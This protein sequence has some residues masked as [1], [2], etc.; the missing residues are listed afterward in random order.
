MHFLLDIAV[1]LHH[2]LVQVDLVIDEV[3][4]HVV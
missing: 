1:L 3:S 4:E 2:L